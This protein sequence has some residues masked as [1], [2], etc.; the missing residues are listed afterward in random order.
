MGFVSL[1]W[2]RGA[3]GKMRMRSRKVGVVHDYLSFFLV[4]FFRHFFIILSCHFLSFFFPFFFVCAGIFAWICAWC[5]AG[6]LRL[7]L[8]LSLR[9]FLRQTASYWKVYRKQTKKSQRKS[10]ARSQ[11]RLLAQIPAQTGGWF[12]VTKR[13]LNGWFFLGKFWPKKVLRQNAFCKGFWGTKKFSRGLGKS[14]VVVLLQT[15]VGLPFHDVRKS[16]CRVP[17]MSVSCPLNHML[18]SK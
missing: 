10:R 12:R 13:N 7:F 16:N 17:E 18:S 9:L 4:I 2:P 1:F 6:M 3:C 5:C 14:Y 11:R 8:R 15:L